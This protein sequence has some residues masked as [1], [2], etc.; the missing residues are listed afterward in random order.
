[1]IGAAWLVLAVGCKDHDELKVD[2]V[3]EVLC[4]CQVIDAAADCAAECSDDL[5]PSEI[6][7]ACVSQM[8]AASSVIASKA[9]SAPVSRT[10]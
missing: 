9:G 7:E 4:R 5:A 1:V 10:P 3:C 8:Q 6:S 2:V